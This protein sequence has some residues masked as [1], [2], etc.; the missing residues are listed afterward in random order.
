ML[1]INTFESGYPNMKK[2]NGKILLIGL[3]ISSLLIGAFIIFRPSNEDDYVPE[4]PPTELTTAAP[5]ETIPPPATE[6]TIPTEEPTEPTEPPVMLEWIVP[7]YEENSSLVGWLRLPGTAID[8]PIYQSG[9]EYEGRSHEPYWD[10]YLTSNR[11]GTRGEG[12]LYVWPDHQ[13]NNIS[14]DDADLFFVFAHNFRYANGQIQRGRDGEIRQFSEL[15]YFDE[16]EDFWY[17]NREILFSTLYTEDIL[18]EVAWVFE[19]DSIVHSDGSVDIHLV[20][21]DTR[22]I[23]STLF[24]FTQRREFTSEEQFYEFVDLMNEYSIRSSDDFS[25][26]D[27][28]IFLLTCQTR[29]YTSSRRLIIAGRHR[30]Q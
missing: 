28:L 5:T 10:F 8:F 1:T 15:P 7:Y 13:N 19:L 21:P 14:I 18:Y 3:L 16:E 12:E 11:D 23:S 2:I 4:E 9:V 25:Y 30:P 27:R 17:E 24:H 26:G 22:E 29:P 6:V 20:D